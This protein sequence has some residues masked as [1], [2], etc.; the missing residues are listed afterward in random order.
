MLTIFL[1]PQLAVPSASLDLPA[2]RVKNW[3]RGKLQCSELRYIY[4]CIIYHVTSVH[5][6]SKY[7]STLDII[8]LGGYISPAVDIF[9]Y[10][11]G[12]YISPPGNT[13]LM[14]PTSYFSAEHQGQQPPCLLLSQSSAAMVG[15]LTSFQSY[16]YHDHDFS[17]FEPP[18]DH[19]H[20]S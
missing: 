12:G 10:I 15:P 3:T 1:C 20:N 14:E 6:S 19:G 18:A 4:L 17:I 9:V 16:H 8:L 13:G 11:S 2:P 5:L 7:G